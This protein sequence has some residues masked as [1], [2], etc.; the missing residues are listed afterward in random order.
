MD[1]RVQDI[2]DNKFQIFQFAD[3]VFGRKYMFRATWMR[4]SAMESIFAC[5]R[6]VRPRPSLYGGGATALPPR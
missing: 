6:A 1:L 4:H 3:E 5:V 2:I